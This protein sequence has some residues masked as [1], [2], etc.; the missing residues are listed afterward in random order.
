MHG[1]GAVALAA[2]MTGVREARGESNLHPPTPRFRTR[3]HW[4]S[5]GRGKVLTPVGPRLWLMGIYR[6]VSEFFF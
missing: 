4:S 1:V 5:S 6:A 3:Q 2:M